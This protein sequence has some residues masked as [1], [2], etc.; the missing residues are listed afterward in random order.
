MEWS[1]VEWPCDEIGWRGEVEERG[2]GGEG[3]GMG[4]DG[5][6]RGFQL[7]FNFSKKTWPE[8]G[9]PAKLVIK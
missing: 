4:G 5:D 9:N 8:P 3:T 2:S 7:E 1:G 6:G